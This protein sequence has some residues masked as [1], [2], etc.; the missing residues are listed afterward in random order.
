MTSTIR[1]T[2]TG[3]ALVAA[4]TLGGITS[5]CAQ[6]EEQPF[7]DD[8]VIEEVQTDAGQ[9][10]PATLTEG[11]WIYDGDIMSTGHEW[12]GVAGGELHVCGLW[13]NFWDIY[14][15]GGTIETS[16]CDVDID[17]LWVTLDTLNASR[18]D[19]G[20]GDTEVDNFILQIGTRD[21]HGET[22]GVK[23]ADKH[24]VVSGTSVYYDGQEVNM[25]GVYD[26]TSVQI[27][28]Y[29][30]GVIH[31]VGVG[32]GYLG[33]YGGTIYKADLSCGHI[34]NQGTINEL[35]YMTSGTLVN[36]GHIDTISD[37]TG[38]TIDNQRIIDEIE[39]SGG[40]LV[41]TD[42]IGKLAVAGGA[43]VENKDV[44]EEVEMWGGMLDNDER[45][46]ALTM[47]GGTLDNAA[48][49]IGTL[50]Y[51]GGTILYEGNIGEIIYVDNANVEVDADGQDAAPLGE[52]VMLW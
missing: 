9:P 24:L 32:Y 5:A 27:Q 17:R 21:V 22:F 29:A 25:W 47:S 3:A 10:M 43:Y 1:T 33:N 23:V 48:G 42:Y 6:T 2:L 37:M 7:Y 15:K 14:H 36:T 4:I 41:N 52:E 34:D 30:D 49:Y 50:Y 44:V 12:V 45:I 26:D 28:N 16:S 8:T 38:G 51:S 13:H 40:T 18:R 31:S 11:L 46:D 20:T 39:M 35:V 19:I